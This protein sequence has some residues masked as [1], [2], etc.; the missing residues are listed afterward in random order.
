M[1]RAILLDTPSGRRAQAARSAYFGFRLIALSQVTHPTRLSEQSVFL[2]QL[3][4]A[5]PTTPGVH[6]ALTVRYVVQPDT[7]TEDGAPRVECFLLA[8]VTSYAENPRTLRSR[9]GAF[10]GQLQ[11]L[12]ETA[13][14]DYRFQPLGT[15]PAVRAALRPF[16]PA[17]TAEIRH[18]PVD[19]LPFP[20]ALPYR[21]VPDADAVVDV[22]LRQHAPTSFEI[23]LEPRAIGPL[24][25][26]SA[27]LPPSSAT[28]AHLPSVL[29]RQAENEGYHPIEAAAP[30]A[31]EVASQRMLLQRALTLQ[32]RAFRLR[33]QVASTQAL[34]PAL[35]AA[36]AAEVG[37][38]GR[39]AS[40]SVWQ[41]SAP[42][43]GD[44]AVAVH[45]RTSRMPGSNVSEFAVALRNLRTL[46]A[47]EWG[48][49]G[50]RFADLS[51]DRYADLGEA[52]RLLTLPHAAHWFS[53]QSVAQALP[54]R[55]GT[56]EGLLLGVNNAH[57]AT[58]PVRLPTA[59]RMLHLWTVG[60][61]GTGKS[62]LLESLI[63]QD[64]RAGRAVLVIDPHGDLIEQILGKIPP[65]R[66]RDVILFDPADT[67]F[68]LGINPLEATTEDEQALVVSSFIGML[69]KIFD[70]Q[71][72]GIVGPRFEHAARNGL[73]TVMSAPGGGTLIEF[74]RVFTDMSFVHTLLPHIKDPLVRRY[75]TDQISNTSDFHKS[76]VLDYVVSKFGP[77]VTDFTVRRIIGQTKSSFSFRK[78]M[79]EGKIVLMSLAKGRLGST[80]ANFLGLI[81]LP[82]ILQAALSRA[83]VELSQ[84]NDAVLYVDEF[85][86]YATDSL[87]LMMAESRKYRLALTLANQHV[88]QLTP[89]I[90]D[91]LLGN[92]ANVLSFRLGIADAEAMTHMLAPS[93]L[94]TRDITVLPNYTA[95]GRIMVNGQKSPAFTLE[96]V[97]DATKYDAARAARIREL[98]RKHYGR[99]R[100][101]VDEEINERAHL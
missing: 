65:S 100:A 68:P 33:L 96:T 6:C 93:P 91:A 98:S 70:P 89:E 63:L 49:P 15:L 1:T 19:A 79:D 86:N 54:F 25:D 40:E 10:A 26:L 87:A 32:Q 78:A 31:V 50:P 21:G 76:E 58:R 85:Q 13:L 7:L 83:N 39:L 101:Q 42:V 20:Y 41:G 66:A 75:W 4:Q 8:R 45:P 16:E 62:T 46:D 69:R 53:S 81:L 47:V 92:V 29:L 99:P 9:A 77:F 34:E 95:Y 35:L 67:A 57:G 56:T 28:P 59:S 37:G 23:Y 24:T 74:M 18:L 55:A 11:S 52:S 82:M 2:G 43:C 73:L 17:D 3:A 88:G 27:H 12:L 94:T 5:V 80:N 44:Y 61:T 14:P 90:R 84:R 38:P 97:P 48:P 30:T 36:V 71:A 22:M 51:L 72:L 64:I 60:Q